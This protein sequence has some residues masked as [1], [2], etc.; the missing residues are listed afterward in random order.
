[1]NSFRLWHILLFKQTTHPLLMRSDPHFPEPIY[2]V[3]NGWSVYVFATT[4]LL[5][6]STPFLTLTGSAVMR[7]ATIAMIAAFIPVAVFYFV[8][9]IVSPY[10]L[11]IGVI[12]GFNTCI[13]VG[14]RLGRLHNADQ[15]D[16]MSVTPHG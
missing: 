4:V 15:I 9:I 6:G 14:A 2:A 1:M 12:Q 11:F 13:G 3:W 16:M 5:M 7:V 10:T 8:G